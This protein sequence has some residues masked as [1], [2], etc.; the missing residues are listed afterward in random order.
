[1]A[2][3]AGPIDARNMPDVCRLVHE[4]NQTGRA[5]LIQVGGEMARLSPARPRA[6]A[7]GKRPTPEAIEAALAAAGSWK[8]LIDPEEFKRQR[9]ELQIDDRPVRS[10]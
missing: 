1:M 7:Q 5:R 2:Q 9:Q 10:L 6:R 3:E 4:V 8:G